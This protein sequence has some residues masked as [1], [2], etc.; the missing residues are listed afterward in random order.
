[1]NELSPKERMKIQRHVMPAQVPQERV[2]NFDE[3]NQGFTPEMA[4]EEAQRC[5][6]CKDAPCVQGCPVHIQIP[7]FIN[8]IVSGK[9]MNA[10]DVILEDNLLPAV[11]GRV[12]PQEKFCES[13]CE[14]KP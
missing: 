11:C 9:S 1:M 8:Q 10:V 3:V 12:C 4:L 14:L 13:R 2:C 7:D 5:L 6:Q